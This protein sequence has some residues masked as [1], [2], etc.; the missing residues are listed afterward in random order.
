MKFWQI[1]S[2]LENDYKAVQRNGMLEHPY[3]LPTVDCE[4]CGAM[5]GDFA[6]VLPFECP[7]AMLEAELLCNDEVRITMKEFRALAKK[8]SRE[9]PKGAI[10][11]LVPHAY[12]QPGFLTVPAMPEDDFLWSS[13]RSGLRAMLVSERVWRVLKKARLAEVEFYPCVLKSVGARSPKSRPRIAESGEPE[14]I[15]EEFI[16]VK[17]LPRI[18]YFQVL[19]SAEAEYPPGSEPSEVCDLCGEEIRP[20]WKAKEAAWK[21]LNN[22]LIG[23]LAKGLDLFRMPGK[24]MV[25]VTDKLKTLLEN[26]LSAT[27]VRFRPFPDERGG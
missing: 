4:K 13:L 8:M 3:R 18:S 2:P 25:F 16:P 27:N 15:L 14:A 22:E 6:R 17:K 10:K 9:L 20:D 21:K 7:V 1:D 24:G 5:V 19:I 23:S 26:E 12:F 11:K